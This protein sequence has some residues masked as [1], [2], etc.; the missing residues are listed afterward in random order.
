MFKFAKAEYNCEI[1]RDTGVVDVDRDGVHIGVKACFCQMRRA[2]VEHFGELFEIKTLE[3]YEGRNA[4]MREAKGYISRH[5]DKSFYV[6]GGVGLGK[7]H[8]LAAI[9]EKLYDS[10]KWQSS[11]IYK[12]SALLDAVRTGGLLEKIRGYTTFFIDDLGKIKLAPWECEAL[13]NFYDDV[14]RFE[15]QVIISS[16]YS[17]PEI[18]EYYGGA[19]TRRIEERSE[20]I[21]IKGAK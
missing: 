5:I 8:L 21:E 11:I 1:C 2:K 6:F 19:I 14:Y 10:G 7:T 13:F 18:G 4:S 20:I 17:L 16:N 9:Y 15:K 12:E 3:N